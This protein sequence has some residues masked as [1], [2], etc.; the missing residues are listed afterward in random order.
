MSILQAFGVVSVPIEKLQKAVGIGDL[1][2]A[3]LLL[4]GRQKQNSKVGF[5]SL[6]DMVRE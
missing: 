4:V 1:S 6:S 2:V 3:A 5:S